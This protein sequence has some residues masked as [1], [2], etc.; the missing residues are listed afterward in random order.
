MEPYIS[1]QPNAALLLPETERIA[2]SIL[3]LPTGQA[4]NAE[5]AQVICRIIETAFA[6]ARAVRAVLASRK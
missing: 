5:T 2:A 4:V 6:N 3:L 1:R